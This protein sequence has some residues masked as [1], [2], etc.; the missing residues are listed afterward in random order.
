MECHSGN[1]GDRP[2]SQRFP[3]RQVADSR[4]PKDRRDGHDVG[5]IDSY[6]YAMLGG[7]TRIISF[8]ISSRKKMRREKRH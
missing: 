6:G 3:A 1:L 8:P 2:L 7:V 4:D 5:I